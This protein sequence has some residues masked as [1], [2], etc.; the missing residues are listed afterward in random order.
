MIDRSVAPNQKEIEKIE[1]VKAQTTVFRS[2]IQCHSILQDDCKVVKLELEF[3]AGSNFQEKALIATMVNHMILEG[4]EQYSAYEIASFF[5]NE[6]A[7]LDTSCSTD[8]ASIVLH[9]LERSIPKLLPYLQAIL[10]TANF[11][12]KEI[13]NYLKINAQKFEVNQEKVGWVARNEFMEELLGKDHP[14]SWKVNANN[15]A[16]VQRDDIISFYNKRYKAATF[17]IY[18]SGKVSAE[19]LHA[20]EDVFNQKVAVRNEPLI[21][22]T[23]DET[24]VSDLKVIEKKGAIQSAI[25]LGAVTINRSHADFPAL[26]V[27]NTILGGYFGSRLMSNIREDKGYTYGIGSGVTHL[28][29][30]SYFIVS[31]EVGAEV[32]A[33]TLKEI[34]FEMNQ[35]HNVLV[36]QDEL[37]L[38][39]NYILG[40][41]MKGFDGSFNAMARFQMLNN[42]G[43]SYG[44]YEN[45][46]QEIKEMNV[47]KIQ[48]A[49]QNF[50]DYSALKKIVVGKL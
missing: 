50:M 42:Q 29:K 22:M 36:S 16:E 44:Y 12:Q 1:F 26:F 10:Y 6:G 31:T 41:I 4:C 9:C 48:A 27:A 21:A 11:P 17:Q 18:L 3:E 15:Y 33:S 2:G 45:L 43:L 20:V 46:I 14:Y 39:K 47:E 19:V 5:D 34:E 35:L 24:K 40:N 25:R 8:K 23:F 49:A 7:F 38:V 13:E 30:L 32:T 28:E 37:K